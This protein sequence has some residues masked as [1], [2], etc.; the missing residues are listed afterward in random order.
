MSLRITTALSAALLALSTPALGQGT[1]KGADEAGFVT[2]SY[3]ETLQSFLTV[4]DDSLQNG[5][6]YKAFVFSGEE[7]DSLSLTL[8]SIDF[9]VNLLLADSSDTIIED[10]DNSGGACNAHLQYELPTTGRYIV[11][12]TST[13]PHQTGQFNI[14][15][16]TGHTDPPSKKRCR[17]FLEVNDTLSVGDSIPGKLGPPN[18]KLGKSFFQVWALDIPWARRQRSICFR[19]IS[20]PG[21]PCSKDSPPPVTPT[22]TAPESA[23]PD[24]W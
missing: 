2:M 1:P 24:S 14:S 6:Y 8:S 7:G 3:G 9:N 18:S 5:Y 23:T 12:A 20:M 17:G 21:W 15:L 10:D 22:M 13:T 16:A 11:Y 19:M 4:N